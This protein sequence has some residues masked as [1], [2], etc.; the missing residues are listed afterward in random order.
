MDIDNVT[1]N[2]PVNDCNVE[3]R[4]LYINHFTN[5][6]PFKNSAILVSIFNLK[7]YECY[8]VIGW[9][10]AS[11]ALLIRISSARSPRFGVEVAK[12]I[13]FKI[14]SDRLSDYKCLQ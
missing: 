5:T 13:Y 11:E 7:L 9:S 8:G 12:S 1:R 6:I 4:T 2:A 10:I 14:G 3:L